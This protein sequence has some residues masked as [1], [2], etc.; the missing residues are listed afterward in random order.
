MTRTPARLGQVQLRILQVL[1]RLGPSTARQIVDEM[2]K[3]AKIARSTVQTLLRQLEAKNIVGH[4]ELDGG[5]FLFHAI[6]KETDVAHTA[7]D[8]LL[9]RVFQGSLYNLVAHLLKP[10]R[11][12][13]DEL[14]KLRDL[15]ESK[16]ET[17]QEE[18]K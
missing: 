13:Q 1:W 6:S 4:T 7:A 11:L 12:S 2:S 15:I 10:E 3:S 9:D 8:D 17:V 5:V 18:L 14:Q 16:R